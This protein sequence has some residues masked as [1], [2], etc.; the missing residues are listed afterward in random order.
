MCKSRLLL[1]LLSINFYWNIIRKIIQK[2]LFFITILSFTDNTKKFFTLKNI[3]IVKL[4]H[5][6][7]LNNILTIIFYKKIPRKTMFYLGYRTI[8]EATYVMNWIDE[9][10]L[11]NYSLAN[12]DEILIDNLDNLFLLNVTAKKFRNMNLEI[13]F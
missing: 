9:Q 10:K 11:P 6:M 2:L 5:I 12:Y 13:S 4:L 3:N 8:F 7:Y 1:L